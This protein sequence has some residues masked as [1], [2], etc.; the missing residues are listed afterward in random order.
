MNHIEKLIEQSGKTQSEIAR[1]VGVTRNEISKYKTGKHEISAS[2]FL[3]WCK[4]LDVDLSV[5][6]DEKTEKSPE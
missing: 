4:K 6:E 5:F 1:I 2:R 3:D